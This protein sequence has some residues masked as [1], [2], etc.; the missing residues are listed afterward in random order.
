MFPVKLLH[1]LTIMHAMIHRVVV[2]VVHGLVAKLFSA[3]E[4]LLNDLVTA[5]VTLFE[6]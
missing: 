2:K 6:I 5:L 1:D 4:M 3:M